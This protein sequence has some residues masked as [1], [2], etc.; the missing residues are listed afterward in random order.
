MHSA[1]FII[2]GNDGLQYEFDG[3]LWNINLKAILYNQSSK[4]NT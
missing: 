2:I 4:E 1:L 3:Q